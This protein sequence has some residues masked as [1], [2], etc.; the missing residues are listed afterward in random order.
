MPMGVVLLLEVIPPKGAKEVYNILFHLKAATVAA[1][2]ALV[3]Q[4]QEKTV[5]QTAATAIAIALITLEELGKVRQHASLQTRSYGSFLAAAQ[6]AADLAEVSCLRVAKVVKAVE[7]MAAP[8]M[9]SARRGNLILAAALAATA[10]TIRMQLPLEALALL[11]SAGAI[12]QQARRQ[13]HE[14]RSCEK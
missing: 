14:I 8:E 13:A 5:A 10:V 9:L 7:A 12:G 3:A 2:V 1:E 4:A 11:L 6:V